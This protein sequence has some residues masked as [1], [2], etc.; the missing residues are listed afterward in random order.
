MKFHMLKALNGR[1]KIAKKNWGQKWVKLAQEKLR[2][3]AIN[4]ICEQ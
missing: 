2:N 4:A 1:K 3:Y